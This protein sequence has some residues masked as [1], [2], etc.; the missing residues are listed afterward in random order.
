VEVQEASLDPQELPV[1]PAADQDE[2][3]QVEQTAE[4]AQLAKEIQEET[5]LAQ[6]LVKVAEVAVAQEVLVDYQLPVVVLKEV[7]KV[8][9]RHL[10]VFLDLQ[11]IIRVAAV[12]LAALGIP[13][14]E[15]WAGGGWEKKMQLV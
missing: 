15:D 6:L 7:V 10:L 8:V 1:D 9:R 12:V 5:E 4:L 3:L 11:Y 13:L 14:A 2:I